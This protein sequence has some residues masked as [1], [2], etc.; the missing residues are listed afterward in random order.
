MTAPFDITV[1]VP[2]EAGRFLAPCGMSTPHALAEGCGV[3]GGTV[4]VIRET[5]SSQPAV[6]VT[7]ED[8][9]V[10]LT[11]RFAP[12][13]TAYPDAMFRPHPSRHTRAAEALVAEA[14]GAAGD[15]TG[16]ERARRLACWAAEQFTYGHPEERFTDGLDHVPLLG[17]GMVAGSCVDIN[18]YFLAALRAAGIEAGY[19]AGF[20][21]PAEKGDWCEDAHCWVVTRHD[22]AVLEWDIAHHLKMGTRDIHPALNPKPGFRAAL[23]HSMGLDFPDLAIADLKLLGQPVA[24]GP[25]GTV[26]PVDAAFAL[27]H[28]DVRPGRVRPPRE[29]RP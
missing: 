2:A 3:A 13:A 21:F 10:T 18:T 24:P 25:N 17:C 19:V 11:Y 6:V 8:D 20:F 4:R 26:V 5:H 28:P 27:H 12:G 1:T 16:P 23:F 14:Q 15:G 29:C 7:P 22:G 9:G